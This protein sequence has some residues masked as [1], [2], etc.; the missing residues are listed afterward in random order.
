MADDHREKDRAGIEERGRVEME[1]L[2]LDELLR[3]DTRGH[4]EDEARHVEHREEDR[5]PSSP[6]WYF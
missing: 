5:L 3:L 2:Q 6:L 4:I 1:F